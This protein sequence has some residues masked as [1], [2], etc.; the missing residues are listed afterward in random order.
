MDVSNNPPLSPVCVGPA[1]AA[2]LCKGQSSREAP[3][4]HASVSDQ[5][6]FLQPPALFLSLSKL[7]RPNMTRG[8]LVPLR[9][10]VTQ[11]YWWLDLEG[12]VLPSDPKQVLCMLPPNRL[13]GIPVPTFQ[14]RDSDQKLSDDVFAFPSCSSPCCWFCPI[15]RS[16]PPV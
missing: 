6:Q 15:N 9:R 3:G 12:V 7:L 2:D 14:L 8:G 1:E 4:F 5:H 13:T 16:L 11:Y 10:E